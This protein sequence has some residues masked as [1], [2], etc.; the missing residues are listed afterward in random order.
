MACVAFL[1]SPSH[2]LINFV[3]NLHFLDGSDDGRVY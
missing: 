3:A 2:F 1:G